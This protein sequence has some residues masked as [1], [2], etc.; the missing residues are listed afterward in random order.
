[1][2]QLKPRVGLVVDVRECRALWLLRNNDSSVALSETNLPP[3]TR[4][5]FCVEALRNDLEVL[6]KYLRSLPTQPRNVKATDIASWVEP[7][8][9][10]A[11]IGSVQSIEIEIDK[12]LIDSHLVNESKNTIWLAAKRRLA[13]GLGDIIHSVMSLRGLRE[14]ISFLFTTEAALLDMRR[15]GDTSVFVPEDAKAKTFPTASLLIESDHFGAERSPYAHAS[16]GGTLAALPVVNLLKQEP[17]DEE[18]SN[19][20]ANDA[21]FP[22]FQ[23]AFVWDLIGRFHSNPWGRLEVSGSGFL[24]QSILLDDKSLVER[25]T[26]FVGIPLNNETGRAEDFWGWMAEARVFDLDLEIIHGEHSYLNPRFSIGFGQRWNNRLVPETGSSVPHDQW[27]RS[28]LFR[29]RWNIRNSLVSRDKFQKPLLVT[30]SF[31]VER[32]WWPN[33]T[34]LPSVTAIFFSGDF[35]INKIIKKKE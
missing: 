21:I 27:K 3:A 28:N 30:F 1:V 4:I 24:G 12:Y 29:F 14:L 25:D 22:T 18:T 31:G 7:T 16:F 15:D 35:D 32:E 10:G 19:A 34:G 2:S 11:A 26:D 5:G 20:D 17:S 6:D 8:F 9:H 23:Q 13:P 33:N